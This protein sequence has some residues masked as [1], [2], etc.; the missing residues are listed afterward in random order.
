M[1]IVEANI[2]NNNQ[3]LY[4]V[5]KLDNLYCLSFDDNLDD[6]GMVLPYGKR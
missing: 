2:G 3:P 6:D 1:E 5:T 4:D